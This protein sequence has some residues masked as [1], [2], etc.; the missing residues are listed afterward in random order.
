VQN[1]ANILL[2][3]LAVLLIWW[4]EADL[5]HRPSGYAYQL[6]LSLPGCSSLWSGLSLHPRL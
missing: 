3:G 2:A 4:R 1:P 6:Q 5:N